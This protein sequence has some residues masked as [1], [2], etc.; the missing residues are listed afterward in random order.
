MKKG[1]RKKFTSEAQQVCK[2][3]IPTL[4]P[5]SNCCTRYGWSVLGRS[6]RGFVFQ[7]FERFLELQVLDRVF[8]RRRR[9]LVFISIGFRNRVVVVA[10]QIVRVDCIGDVLTLHF[11]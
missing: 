4:Y 10:R 3:V 8:S 1:L 11:N 7:Q 9:G 6:L 5:I 2:F